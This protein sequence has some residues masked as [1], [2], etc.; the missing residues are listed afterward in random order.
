[1][2]VEGPEEL[3]IRVVSSVDKRMETKPRFL[4]MFPDGE[5]PKEFPYKSKVVLLF[6]RIEGVEVCLYAMYVQEF[7]ADCLPPNHRRIYLS[8]LDSIKYFRPDVRTVN[9]EALRTF[10][11]HEILVSDLASRCRCAC[12]LLGAGESP[13]SSQPPPHLPLLPPLHQVFPPG[14]AHCE[15]RSAAHLRLPRDSGE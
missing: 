13:G 1:M 7:G 9:G 5:Y 15:G 3:V 8:Y 12:L 4:N 2:Q 6:Q 14:R 10:V 11:Y